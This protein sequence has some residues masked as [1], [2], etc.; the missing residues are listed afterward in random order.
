[1]VES[2]NTGYAGRECEALIHASTYKGGCAN[3][4]VN[5]LS[6]EYAQFFNIASAN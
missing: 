3:P 6:E 5:G 1:M 2:A 4:G